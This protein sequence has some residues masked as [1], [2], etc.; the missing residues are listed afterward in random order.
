MSTSHILNLRKSL[1]AFVVTGVLG[2]SAYA[3]VP[4]IIG[5]VGGAGSPIGGGG[6]GV[7]GP[8]IGPITTPG[9]GPINTG[10][11]NNIR[12]NVNNAA[13]QYQ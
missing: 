12:G 9:V 5:G 10:A 1:A 7:I 4:G 8:G 6:A 11:V 2:A 13:R 3:Q